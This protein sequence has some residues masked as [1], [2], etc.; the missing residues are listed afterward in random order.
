MQNEKTN[1]YDVLSLGN[2]EIVGFDEIKKAYRS[3]AL[4][5]HPAVCPPSTKEEST[6][7]FVE[8]QKAYETL[9]DPI[10]RQRYDYELGLAHNSLG[11]CVGKL[12]REERRESFPK[13]VWEKQLSGLRKRSGLRMERKKNGCM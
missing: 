7:R 9:S 5:Y 11:C 13:E 10:S 2:P 12:C 4:Q 8:L 3:M 1:F 6:T